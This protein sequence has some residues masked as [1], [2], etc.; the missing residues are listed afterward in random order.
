M[1]RSVDKNISTGS[2]ID[3][4]RIRSG[5]YSWLDEEYAK[6]HLSSLNTRIECFTGFSTKNAEKYQIVH[7]GLSGPY[8]IPHLDPHTNTKV[9]IH[10]YYKI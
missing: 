2:S 10:A 9:R 7:Y 5:Q 4:C 1:T 8:Q 6:E 3:D